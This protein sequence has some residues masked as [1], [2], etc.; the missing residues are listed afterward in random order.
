VSLLPRYDAPTA[1]DLKFTLLGIPVRVHP[2]FWLTMFV[3][4]YTKEAKILVVRLPAAALSILIHEYGHALLMRWYGGRPHIVLYAMGGYAQYSGRKY[5]WVEQ[6]INRL[7]EDLAIIFAGPLAPLIVSAVIAVAMLPLGVVLHFQP[8]YGMPF[9]DAFFEE[10]PSWQMP[11]MLKEFLEFFI[12]ISMLWSFFNLLPILPL[13]GGR[14]ASAILRYRDVPRYEIVACWISIITALSAIALEFLLPGAE[15][16]SA[17]PTTFFLLMLAG[18]NYHVAQQ[19][20]Q[21]GNF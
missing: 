4:C 20:R 8:M 9:F 11:R 5:D 17:L 13:D 14:I 16:Q 6:P 2:L 18:M 7:T 19:L 1:Y 21:R 10:S 15:V 3:L 12:N